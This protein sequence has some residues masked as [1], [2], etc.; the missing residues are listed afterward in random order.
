METPPVLT[1][2]YLAM[3]LIRR[4][5]LPQGLLGQA[6]DYMLKRWEALTRF[7]D[8]GVLEIDN[9]I[10]ENAIRPGALGKK[11]WLF[12]G[13]PRAG[14]R[15]AVI[16]TL[17]GSCRRPAV[18]R[19]CCILFAL[20]H[21]ILPAQRQIMLAFWRWI[22]DIRLPYNKFLESYEKHRLVSARVRFPNRRFQSVR[23]RHGLH[24]SRPAPKQR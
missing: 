7:V 13:H 21:L 16:Y 19:S 10:I 18:R 1:R 12:V 8:D 24:L 9:N 4:R 6:I 14:E 5:I 23:P 2:L 3:E 11:N 17:L 22:C 15:S 20:L